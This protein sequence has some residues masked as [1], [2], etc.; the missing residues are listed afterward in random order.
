MKNSILF[1][2]FAALM[3]LSSCMDTKYVTKKSTFD[4]VVSQ[5]RDEMSQHGLD[6]TGYNTETKNDLVVVHTSHHEN[7]G[8]NS[9]LKNNYVTRDTYHFTDAHGN[10]ASYTVSYQLKET[11]KG[12]S[13]VDGVEVVGCEVSSPA[14]YDKLCGM[15]SP[16]N[17][18]ATMDKDQ[19]IRVLNGTR[20]VILAGG[21]TLAGLLLLFASN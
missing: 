3:S 1:F 20:T 9:E 14:D 16:T 5:V 10:K 6:L 21:I 19:R 12:E 18:I 11:K 4:R 2:C 13:Y 17:R 8:V 15:A 7:D